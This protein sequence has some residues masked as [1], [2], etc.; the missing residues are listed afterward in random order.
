[1]HLI[2]HPSVFALF[3]TLCLH[4]GADQC[5]G[6]TCQLPTRTG[7]GTTTD[8]YH[9]TR[10]E[11]SVP[12]QPG[13]LQSLGKRDWEEGKH[14]GDMHCEGC[15]LPCLWPHRQPGQCQRKG[16]YPVSL[17]HIPCRK[18]W[19]LPSVWSVWHSLLFLS[20]G[21]FFLVWDVSSAPVGKTHR[22]D[23]KKQQEGGRTETERKHSTGHPDQEVLCNFLMLYECLCMYITLTLPPLGRW[24]SELQLQPKSR[25][26]TS[27]EPSDLLFHYC[28]AS[29]FL[30]MQS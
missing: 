29:H 30:S 10:V 22:R 11:T 24:L 7:D 20:I 6:V 1:M 23:G 13:K 12:V 3:P 27:H 9:D 14:Q 15:V 17:V 25:Q 26:Q 2:H 16:L 8:Q 4:S 5:Q 19:H 18:L 28:H 21:L